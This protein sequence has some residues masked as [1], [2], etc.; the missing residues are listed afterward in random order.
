MS[1][2]SCLPTQHIQQFYLENFFHSSQS[3]LSEIII[4]FK[5]FL[6][7]RRTFCYGLAYCVLTAMGK[8][9]YFSPWYNFSFCI[10]EVSVEAVGLVLNLQGSASTHLV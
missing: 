6:G 1:S 3:Q 9:L 8:Q 5:R 4:F 7:G 2:S 10:S